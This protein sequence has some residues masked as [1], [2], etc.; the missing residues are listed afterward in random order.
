LSLA[1]AALRAGQ[2]VIYPT[3]TLYAL[4]AQALSA[5]AVRK[6]RAAKQREADKALPLVAS[7]S[8]QA[9]TLCASW[10]VEAKVLADRFWPGP[11]TFVVAAAASL[12]IEVT[13]GTGSVAIRVPALTLARRLCALAGPLISTSANVAGAAAPSTCDEAVAALGEAV[14]LALDAGPGGQTPSTIVDLTGPAPRLL[15]PGAVPWPAVE[16]ALRDVRS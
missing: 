13:A 2:L 5:P 15:R 8:A 11:L 1:A 4:G 7:D 12:P 3:D 6:V 9:A 16:E 14:T 10:P